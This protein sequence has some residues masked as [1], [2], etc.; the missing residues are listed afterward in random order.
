MFLAGDGVN[1]VVGDI[2][3]I[4]FTLLHSYYCCLCED[5]MS[6]KN[7]RNEKTNANFGKSRAKTFSSP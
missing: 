6:P 2:Q 3:G 7:K 1:T 4:S 5:I